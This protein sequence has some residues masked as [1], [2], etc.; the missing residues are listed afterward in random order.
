MLQSNF[1]T[2]HLPDLI[3]NEGLPCVIYLYIDFRFITYRVEGDVIDRAIYD[4][5]ERNKVNNIFIKKEDY[6]KFTDWV[7]A[8]TLG[9]TAEL[10][11]KEFKEVRDNARRKLMDVFHSNH[12]DKMV[13]Q[14]IGASKKIVVELMR[15]PYAVKS[16]KQLQTYSQGTVEHSVNVSILSTYL[17]MQMGYTHQTILNHVGMGGL[18][19]DIGKLVVTTT[20]DDTKETID[21]KML[22]HPQL[23][24]QLLEK[25]DKIPEEVKMII[26]QHHERYDGMGVPNK[27]RGAQI[28]DLARIVSIANSFDEFVVD[29]PSGDLNSR[30]QHAVK[31]LTAEVNTGRF[32]P[33]KLQKVLKILKFGV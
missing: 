11:S 18:L 7:Q 29:A 16:L 19:H 17:A 31:Q 27:L 28:Y 1:I 9:K 10:L 4:R 15:T 32:D 20:D 14:A 24:V 22:G 26:L 3:P 25:Q 30:Q 23:G 2:C 21:K 6:K 8:Q 12:P 13:A 5:L 33:T